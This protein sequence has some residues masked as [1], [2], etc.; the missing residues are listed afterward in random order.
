MLPLETLEAIVNKQADLLKQRSDAGALSDD[1][2][3]SLL[4]LI[5]GS[6]ALAGLTKPAPANPLE[7]MTDEELLEKA[8]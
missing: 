7:G 6:L 1:D 3:E 5:K 4:K 2:L 8:K